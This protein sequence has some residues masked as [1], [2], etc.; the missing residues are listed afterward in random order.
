MQK[1]NNS[2]KPP[3]EYQAMHNPHSHL[4]LL[5]CLMDCRFVPIKL[6]SPGKIPLEYLNIKNLKLEQLKKSHTLQ[7]IKIFP[8][9]HTNG[10]HLVNYDPQANYNSLLISLLQQLLIISTPWEWLLLAFGYLKTYQ[11]FARFHCTLWA[12][13]IYHIQIDSN[14]IVWWRIYEF[15][16]E[17]IV[18]NDV[19][20][21]V[22]LTWFVWYRISFYYCLVQQWQ[23]CHNGSGYVLLIH[24]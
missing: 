20:R 1:L 10:F 21:C 11:L 16:L 19:W 18:N 2:R 23:F 5:F 7:T 17:S 12:P 14:R 9:T 15:K 6:R 22:R 24:T 8:G 4:L 3:T 13:S